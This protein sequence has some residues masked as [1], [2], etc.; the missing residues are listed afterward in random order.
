MSCL[1]PLQLTPRSLAIFVNAACVE[2]DSTSVCRYSISS[3]FDLSVAVEVV[4]TEGDILLLDEDGTGNGVLNFDVGEGVAAS[5]SSCQS[6]LLAC[7][8]SSMPL[9]VCFWS[10]ARA[11][12]VTLSRIDVIRFRCIC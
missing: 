12:V 10:P 7:I 8:S 4:E 3:A 6:T 11:S 5:R 9:V 1:E 2:A